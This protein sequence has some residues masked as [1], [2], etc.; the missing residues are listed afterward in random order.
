M[1]DF[2]KKF[3]F[4]MAFLVATLIISMSFGGKVTEYFLLLVLASMVVMNTDKFAEITGNLGGVKD[5]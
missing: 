4:I 2:Y 3:T 1:K 5:E